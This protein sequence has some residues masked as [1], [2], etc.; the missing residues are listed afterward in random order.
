MAQLNE[1]IG[2]TVF[3]ATAYTPNAFDDAVA[4]AIGGP[5]RAGSL[6]TFQVNIGLTC[7]L[8]CEHCHVESSPNRR[9]Q[10][11]WETMELI[12]DAAE[13]AGST[14]LDITG[15][16]PE[17]NPYFRRFVVAARAQGM[18]V[19]VRTNLTI[20]LEEGYED[21]PEF[22]RE[23]GVSLVASLPCYL[24]ENVDKQRGE[25]VYEESVEVLQRLN[26]VGFGVDPGLELNLVYNPGGPSLPPPT[27][28]LERDYKK[29]LS[30]RWGITFNSLYTITNVPI[31]RFMR[32]LRRAGKG[33]AYDQLLR[34]RFNCATIEPLMC[35]HQV[36]IS[37]DG[38][39]HDCDFNYALK[40]P[41]NDVPGTHIR[42]FD[43][44]VHGRRRVATGEHCFACTA[45]AG[46][47]CSGALA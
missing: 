31:G 39:M 4:D 21:M 13:R 34:D 24:P 42:D 45:G 38:T 30:E 20:L 17:M 7:N 46:S 33:D 26:A 6:T 5:L 8:A 22:F 1:P 43:P 10:M 11:D 3:G 28:Q 9:E 44:E 23:Q 15:G 36:H 16:A 47:S 37:H 41:V 32:D 18:A 19:N 29:V 35:R 2:L 40:M 12:L 27:E 25:H 14:D